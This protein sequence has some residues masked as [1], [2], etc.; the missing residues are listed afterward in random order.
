MHHV[1]VKGDILGFNYLVRY[2]HSNNFGTYNLPMRSYNNS[3]YCSVQKLV[4]QAWNLN[5]GIAVAADFG[6][7]FGN[8]FGAMLT[9]SRRGII[10]K[11]KK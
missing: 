10:W 6:T 7:Q 3:I 9:I 11:S 4:P 1:A 5:F 8:S 2:S